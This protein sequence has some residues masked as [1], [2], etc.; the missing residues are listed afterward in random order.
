MIAAVDHARDHDLE[1]AVYRGGHGVRGHAVC[2]GG[3]VID[4]RPM[5]RIGIDA[6]RRRARVQAGATWLEFDAA[7]Q[8]YGLAVTGGRVSSTGVSGFTLGSGSGWPERK[9]GLTA[10]R[11]ISAEMILA[12]G[13][14]VTVFE[15][16]AR[17]CSGHSANAAETLGIVTSFEFAPRGARARRMPRAPCVSAT[18]EPREPTTVTRTPPP[19]RCCRLELNPALCPGTGRR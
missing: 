8:A 13:P 14:L 10:D 11:L 7:A 19:V 16:E 17:S 9:L 4:L 2:D 18:S 1:I 15:R 12:D 3:M 5:N 6:S